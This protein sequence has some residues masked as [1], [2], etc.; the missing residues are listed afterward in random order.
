MSVFS[1]KKNA[2]AGGNILDNSIHSQCLELL[3]EQCNPLTKHLF[4]LPHTTPPVVWEPL[5]CYR[6]SSS[7]LVNGC[8]TLWNTPTPISLFQSSAVTQH[9]IQ[10]QMTVWWSILWL[11]AERKKSFTVCCLLVWKP[12]GQCDTNHFWFEREITVQADREWS[13]KHRLLFMSMGG[14]G[15]SNSPIREQLSVTGFH[16]REEWDVRR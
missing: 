9:I 11:G 12:V 13:L 2:S 1:C 16:S 3:G 6:W 4:R 15:I 7:H 5:V 10:S 14:R 8:L